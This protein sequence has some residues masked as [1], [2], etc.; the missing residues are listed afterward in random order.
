[1]EFYLRE[2]K[3]SDAKQL[4]QHA[5]DKGIADFLRDAFPYPYTEMDAVSF[6]RSC[7]YKPAGQINRAIIIGE[8][9]AGSIGLFV[10]KDVYRK[11]AELG[12]WLSRR[13]WGH[14]VMTQAV[15]QVCE[16][17]FKNLGIVRIFAECYARCV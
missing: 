3:L 2:W 1:M 8:E 10:Q 7:L 14:G 5:N 9:A 17:G 15:R 13:Y 4:S 12:Y 6:I 11:S 16:E